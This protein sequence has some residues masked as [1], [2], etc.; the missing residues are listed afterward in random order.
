MVCPMY[1]RKGAKGSLKINKSKPDRLIAQ[2]NAKGGEDTSLQSVM[3]V[4]LEES[5][6]FQR[7]T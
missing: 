5:L 3:L 2:T 1:P 6:M 4:L 7:V